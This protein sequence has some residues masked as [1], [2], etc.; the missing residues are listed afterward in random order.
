MKYRRRPTRT[1]PGSCPRYTRSY[2][3]RR[4][5]WSHPASSSAVING[6]SRRAALAAADP[7]VCPI[8]HLQAAGP[9][10]D[11]A[12]EGRRRPRGRQR[13]RSPWASALV[14]RV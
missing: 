9:N 10:A 14:K 7:F 1:T 8:V 4:E 12:I 3:A 11:A 5:Q 2:T 6:D 13:E